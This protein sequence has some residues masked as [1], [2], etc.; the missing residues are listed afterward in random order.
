MERKAWQFAPRWPVLLLATLAVV[1]LAIWLVHRYG[2]T[3]DRYLVTTQGSIAG[4]DPDSTVIYRG[5]EAGE[6][7]AIGF[8]PGDSRTILVQIDLNK[9]LPVTRGTYARLR[10]QGLTGS[11]QIELNDAGEDRDRLLTSEEDPARIPLRPSLIDSRAEAGGNILLRADELITRL[12]VVLDEKTLERMQRLI[13]NMETATE[14]LARL[15]ERLNR[16]LDEV[17]ELST[18]ATET[19]SRV[20]ALVIN[21]NRLSQQMQSL[22]ASSQALVTSG[23]NAADAAAKNALPRLD[24]LLEDLQSTI[25]QL[26]TL[27]SRLARNPRSLLDEAKPPEPGP[28]EPGYEEPR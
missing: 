8:D 13:W 3:H 25:A 16:A 24:Q 18:K 21:L 14:P 26:R 1:A 17:P 2:D 27:S 20:D 10:T 11:L 12:L 4:L 15:Q 9:D 5:V 22:V 6:I 19:M 7:Q 28:G 23:K